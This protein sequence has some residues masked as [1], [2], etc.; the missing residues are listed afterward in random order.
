MIPHRRLGIEI[1]FPLRSISARAAAYDIPN[2]YDPLGNA[3]SRNERSRKN[4]LNRP[5][6]GQKRKGQEPKL[7]DA[8]PEAV[9]KLIS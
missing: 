4:T 2:P 5:E 1:F 7:Q 9:Q 3:N 8:E 6:G